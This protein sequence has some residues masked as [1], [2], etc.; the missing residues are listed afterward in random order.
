MFASKAIYSYVA[1]FRAPFNSNDIQAHKSFRFILQFTISNQIAVSSPYIVC[2]DGK[3]EFAGFCR[4]RWVCLEN[5]QRVIVSI[6][7]VLAV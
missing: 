2:T 5:F 6:H 7:I 1:N 3:C 4:R